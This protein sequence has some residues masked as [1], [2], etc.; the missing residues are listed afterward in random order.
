MKATASTQSGWTSTIRVL[1]QQADPQRARIG[2][3]LVRIGTG[4]RR[5]PIGIAR[6][7]ALHRIQHGG[8]V[9]HA[10]REDELEGHA[11][12][13]LA[14]VGS[15]R[16]A[17]PR[18]LQADQPALAGGVANRAAAIAA[19]GEGNHAG[20]DRC[21]R[22]PARA[23]ARMIRIPG[24]SA[25][26]VGPRFGGGPGAELG[27]VGAAHHDD[28]GGRELL[29][30]VRRRLGP[31]VRIAQEGRPPMMRV[32]GAIAAGEILQQERN[33]SKGTRRERAG[34]LLARAFVVL[35]DD[36]VELRIEAPRS[37][38]SRSR[39]VLRG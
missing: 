23:A 4:G 5:D 8:G 9:A 25:W 24:T 11:A 18:R 7:R 21:C 20:R 2:S 34:G 39:R 36:G 3:H 38:R 19:V 1:R 28:T 17:R 13:H 14:D 37:S 27:N 30:Q 16:D 6:H 26:A 12:P 29:H 35:V 10:A 22:S 15:Q 32:A 31:I 33:A